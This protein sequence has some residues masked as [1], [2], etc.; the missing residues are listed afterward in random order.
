MQK[1]AH[2]AKKKKNVLE[3]NEVSG[4]A[5]A[6]TLMKNDKTPV[7]NNTGPI[8]RSMPETPTRRPTPGQKRTP[9][10]RETA[11]SPSRKTRT[12]AEG[13]AGTKKPTRPSKAVLAKKAIV[14]RKRKNSARMKILTKA[15][16]VKAKKT[17][18]T[19]LKIKL[20][21]RVNNN[22]VRYLDFISF[23]IKGMNQFH[24]FISLD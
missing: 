3:R 4:A 19:R 9:S 10:E 5:V 2:T 17:T 16:R 20:P 24:G 7:K 13:T 12:S 23:Y 14:V 15:K 22:K 18:R 1:K 21:I 11:S 8:K 6:A